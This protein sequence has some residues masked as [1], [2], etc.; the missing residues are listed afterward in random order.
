MSALV[1]G[2]VWELPETPKFGRPEKLVLLAYADHADSNGK[3]IYPSVQLVCKKTFYE[4]RSVQK[5]TRTLETLGLLIADGVGPH[6]TNRWAIPIFITPD[7]GAKIAGVQ[8]ITKAGAENAPEE[9]APKPSLVV[10]DNHLI[11]VNTGENFK[12]YEQEI[13]GLTPMIA[14]AI[15]DAEK[16]YP[17]DWIPEA[18]AIAVQKNI[19]NWKYVEAILANC[20]AKNIRPSLNKLEAKNGNTRKYSGGTTEGKSGTR[21]G[22]KTDDRAGTEYSAADLAAADLI[23]GA[24]GVRQMP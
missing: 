10:K 14:D 17:L 9:N 11:I 7:G 18:I 20:K 6:G 12:I 16:T 13:G 23:N 19:R 8:K 1:M 5:I 4:E 15:K 22:R 21:Q 3:S 24:V 2:L